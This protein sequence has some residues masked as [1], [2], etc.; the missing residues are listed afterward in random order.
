MNQTA[1]LNATLDEAAYLLDL[2][3]QTISIEAWAVTA[4]S[5]F[6]IIFL[7]VVVYTETRPHEGL[8]TPAVFSPINIVL[9]C[10]IICNCGQCLSYWQYWIYLD[11]VIELVTYGVEACFGATVLFF[12]MLYSWIRGRNIVELVMPRIVPFFP[13]WLSLYAASLT[14][15]TTLS[16]LASDISDEFITAFNF[17]SILTAIMLLTF[18]LLVGVCYI[19]YLR[20]MRGTRVADHGRLR[21]VSVYG[22]TS[23]AWMTAWFTVQELIRFMQWDACTLLYVVLNAFAMG[24]PTAFILIQIV[25][26]VALYRERRRE[27]ADRRDTVEQAK[28]AILTSPSQVSQTRASSGLNALSLGYQ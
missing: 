4:I 24:M 13:A 2:Q 23:T 25:M 20:R 14:T 26:K 10:L 16:I 22:C 6:Q 8:P 12:V 7:A 3:A 18:D 1:N 11:P 5:L 9:L 17:T 19:M 15:A 27:A 28:C 21:I